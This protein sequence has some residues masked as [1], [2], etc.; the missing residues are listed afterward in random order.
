MQKLYKNNFN[1]QVVRT[2]I[3]NLEVTSLNLYQEK[4]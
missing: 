4:C 3:S 2:K 1:E